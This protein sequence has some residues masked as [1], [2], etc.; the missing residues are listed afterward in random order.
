MQREVGTTFTLCW[1]VPIIFCTLLAYTDLV[2][3]ERKWRTLHVSRENRVKK[4]CD[5]AY[6]SVIFKS[7]VEAFWFLDIKEW[8]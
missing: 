3:V 5:I 1:C 4:V 7:D 2:V 6:T 8:E